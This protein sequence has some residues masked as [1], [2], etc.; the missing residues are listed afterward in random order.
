MDKGYFDKAKI[1]K[2]QNETIEILAND[3]DKARIKLKMMYDAILSDDVVKNQIFWKNTDNS[4]ISYIWHII[5]TANLYSKDMRANIV[6]IVSLLLMPVSIFTKEYGVNF[7]FNINEM[8]SMEEK[9]HFNELFEKSKGFFERVKKNKSF[10]LQDIYQN[11]LA[12]IDTLIAEDIIDRQAEELYDIVRSYAA[13]DITIIKNAYNFAKEAHKGVM[14]KSGIPYI[15]HPLSVARILAEDK[16]QGNIVA[17]ALLHDVA[18]DTVFTLDDITER[19]N[20]I[21]SR[22]VDAVTQIE[23]TAKGE[24]ETKEDIDN[25]TF[26]KL[27]AMTSTGKKKME[28]ALYIKAADRIHNLST[29]SCFPDKKQLEKVKETRSKYLRLFKEH[30]M[31]NYATQI[32]NLCFKIENEPLYNRVSKEYSKLYRNNVKQIKYIES[33]L[34]KVLRAIPMQCNVCYN[35]SVRFE[36]EII[37]KKLIPSQ[38]KNTIDSATVDINKIE[39]YINKHQ[40]PMENI[41]IVL[42][43]LTDKSTI[44]SF[45]SLF[46]KAHN[47]V[48]EFLDKTHIIKNIEFNDVEDHFIISIQDKYRNTVKCFFMMRNVYNDYQNGFKSGIVDKELYSIDDLGEQITV[49]KRDGKPMQLPKDSCAIDFAYRLH[50]NM[51]SSLYEVIINGKLASPTTILKNNDKVVIKSHTKKTEEEVA[52]D[53]YT[54]EVPWLIYVKTNLAKRTITRFLQSELSKIK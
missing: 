38:I 18:E 40:I 4:Y 46:I 44:R 47:D 30:N 37:T 22:Y 15:S 25:R 1:A 14:R 12:F 35:N 29:I 23:E 3:S 52:Y 13:E 24:D 20:I 19:T 33:S 6:D 51:G 53:D 5:K 21:V 50:T 42:D 54:I 32:E 36:Y 43:G 11:T 17:A 34:N 48:E 31:N 27:L 26:E 28:Y 7:T 49:Y 10:S 9:T 2:F 39:R 41:Y 16:M 45:I 8:L